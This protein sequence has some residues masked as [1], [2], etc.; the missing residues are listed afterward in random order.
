MTK[1]NKFFDD[2]AKM[3][4]S[5]MN[6]FSDARDQ[7]QNEVRAR[8]D[9]AA[10]RLDLVPRADLDAALERLKALETRVTALE[11]GKAKP[12]PKPATAKKAAAKPPIKKAGKTAAKK[13]AAKKTPAKKTAAKKTSKK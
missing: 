1:D 13:P 10:L 3:A 7:I 12:A 11:G 6:M 2:M 8:I 5:A 4:G 9:D